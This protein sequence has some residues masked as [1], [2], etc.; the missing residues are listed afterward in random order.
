VSCVTTRRA[1]RLQEMSRLVI[2]AAAFALLLPATA[3]AD[4]LAAYDRVTPTGQLDIALVNAS[5][6][7]PVALP[8]GVNTAAREFHP[9]LSP[10]ARRLTFVR[11][12]FELRG[13]DQILQAV[14]RI[15]V[16]DLSTRAEITPS[17]LLA[18]D[19][20]TTTPTFASDGA[21]LVVGRHPAGAITD[22][23]IGVIALPSGATSL[24][25][26]GFDEFATTPQALALQA[27]ACG[28][29]GSCAAVIAKTL[30]PAAG[31]AGGVRA[32]ELETSGGSAGERATILVRRGT[33]QATLPAPGDTTDG[34]WSHPAI[35]TGALV[36]AQFERA[37]AGGVFAPGDVHFLDVASATQTADFPQINTPLDEH[38][39]AWLADGRMLAFLRTTSAGHEQL[40]V[41]DTDVAQPLN[42]AQAD[43]GLA[44][45][46][47][48][49]LGTLRRR[50][51]GLSLARL[52]P[53]PTIVC[54][55]A[56]T[57]A[58]LSLQVGTTGSKVG[59]L[60]QR[61]RGT[62]RHQRLRFARRIP[63]GYHRPGR[64]RVHLPRL[65]DGTYQLVA[66]TLTLG[67]KVKD[68]SRPL[69]LD[70]RHGTYRRAPSR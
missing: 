9:S 18:G 27:L 24:V 21:S 17:S 35:G 61:V 22:D 48:D 16:F 50:Q 4:L 38:E 63:L 45:G 34:R 58:F 14:N 26:S 70:V 15:H 49:V 59:I 56:C 62:K 40:V 12:T 43:L 53:P 46:T 47:D 65:A 25:D 51:G 8:A 30:N 11:Q 66:R 31:P 67:N 44:P 68:I 32:W 2:A 57:S 20:R 55:A 13:S 52:T 69:R 23:R 29:G 64:F 42:A 37:G 19:D 54:D 10:D 41:Y 1:A 39:P 36:A 60:V 5:T 6:G 3:R 28:F 7:L 33:A